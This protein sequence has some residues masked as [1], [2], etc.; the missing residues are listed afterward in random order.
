[1]MDTDQSFLGSS[2]NY[3]MNTFK[4]DD[5]ITVTDRPT[6][7]PYGKVKGAVIYLGG[8][9]FFKDDENHITQVEITKGKRRHFRKKSKMIVEVAP[10][11]YALRKNTI[12][13]PDGVLLDILSDDVVQIE[14]QYVR[15]EYTVEIEGIRYLK[16]NPKIVKCQASGEST[17]KEY[18]IELSPKY[19]PNPLFG[20]MYVLRKHAN[21]VVQNEAG[22]YIMKNETHHIFN[23]KGVAVYIHDKDFDRNTRLRQAF[24]KFRNPT[25]PQMDRIDS[26]HFYD[27]DIDNFQQLDELGSLYIHK[28]HVPDFLKLYND[29][30]AI[31]LASAT[32]DLKKA[33]RYSDDGPEENIAKIVKKVEKPWTGK[34][35]VYAPINK[36]V[37]VL[38][39]TTGLT[40]GLQYTFGVEIETSQGICPSKYLDETLTLMVGDGSIGAGEYVTPV[41]HGDT[42]MQY[43]EKLCKA[44]S[45]TCLVDDRCGIHVHVGGMKEIKGVAQTDFNRHFA[46]GAIKLGCL[47]E[48]ELYETCPP[49]RGPELKHCHSILRYKGINDSNWREYLGAYVFG[50]E[51][52]WGS[53]FSMTP[54]KYGDPGVNKEVQVDQWCGGRYKWLN[55]VHILSKSKLGTCELRIFPGSTNF[56]KICNYVL[57]S[58]AFVWMV[59]NRMGMIEKG[60]VTLEQVLTEPFTSHRHPEIAAKLVAFYQARKEKFK[61]TNLYPET[62]PPA[63]F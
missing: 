14:G 63:I 13:T 24:W 40:G 17:F 18:C 59:E 38:S 1:M 15:K 52:K 22:D 28:S 16:S 11:K 25:N 48:K 6:P 33:M 34:S 2:N 36:R 26:I 60:N 3:C 43:L 10:G 41:L 7:V 50:P 58:M 29:I 46:I 4:D 62:I 19:N 12:T 39:N 49:S 51:E 32:A 5:L 61:R 20:P 55:L 31:Q 27:K 23:A 30:I 47:I 53:P 45:N 35:T 9:F 42:G 57:L 21:Q 56:E 44:L 54:Y 8:E 37:P